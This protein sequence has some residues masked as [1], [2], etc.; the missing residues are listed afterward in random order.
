MQSETSAEVSEISQ[1][2]LK[3]Y[4]N[5]SLL[6][7]ATWLGNSSFVEGPLGLAYLLLTSLGTNF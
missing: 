3:Q 7:Y 2:M 5:M 1:K 4:A 6:P